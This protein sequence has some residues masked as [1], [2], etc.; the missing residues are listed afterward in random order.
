MLI[1]EVFA[2]EV[3]D[4]RKMPT[5]SVEIITN[6]GKFK[7]SVPSGTSTGKHEAVELRDKNGSVKKAVENIKNIIAPQIV[8]KNFSNQKEIDNLLLKL[9]GT[10]NKRK[11]GANAILAVSMAACRAF[12]QEN[13]LPL[14]KYIQKISHNKNKIRMPKPMILLFEGGKHADNKAGKEIQEFMIIPRGKRFSDNFETGKK[15][16]NYVGRFLKKNKIKKALGIEGA[17]Y[18]L[19]NELSLEII[20]KIIRKLKVNCKT[21]LDVAASEFFKNKKY[22]LDG[23][24]LTGKQMI[25]MYEQLIKNFK[26]VSIE[27]PFSEEDFDSWRIF[28]KLSKK[29]RKIMLVG[30]D[31]TVSN[32][33]LIKKAINNKLC[34]AMILKINQI[35]TISEAIESFKIA[36]KAGW[37]IIV[38]HRSGE[39]LDDFIA[40]FSV[41]LGADFVKFGAVSQKERMVKYNRL[42]EIEREI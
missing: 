15:I 5:V 4:S 26:I 39:T 22:N 34:N 31:L 36:K 6:S 25:E 32:P 3:L 23:G 41:G 11:L 38:S 18:S 24:K 28:N 13:K 10:T 29:S 9:D 19:G 33:S 37:K 1:K 27:D 42:K 20:Y 12:S 35:G 7:S 30:D 40:D 16:Y 2:K 14:Y 8:N 21:G 17:Y